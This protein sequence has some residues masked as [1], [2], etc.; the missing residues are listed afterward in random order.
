[1]RVVLFDVDG[2]L[3]DSRA[4]HQELW[5]R[6]AALRSLDFATVSATS[7]GRRPVETIQTVAPHLDAIA[8]DALLTQMLAEITT[9]V[10]AYPGAQQL[11][12]ALAPARWGVVTGGREQTV[13]QH[14]HANGLPEPAVLIDAD[15]VAAGKPAPDGYLHAAHAFAV[16]PAECLVVEDAPVGVAAGKAAGMTV[17]AI[18]ST[19]EPT[20]LMDAD[21]CVTDLHSS[22]GPLTQ[23]LTGSP[24]SPRTHR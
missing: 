23:W 5:R 15:A 4:S 21:Q 20:L 24:Q 17:L 22:L 13:L 12:G 16:E 2:V 9:T 10:P 7:R 14:F 18:A 11:L 19:H 3:L 1:M 8:E 6:W